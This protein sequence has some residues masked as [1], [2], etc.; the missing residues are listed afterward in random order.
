MAT[1]GPPDWNRFPDGAADYDIVLSPVAIAT[2]NFHVVAARGRKFQVCV[3]LAA[4]V[5]L[6]NTWREHGS[7]DYSV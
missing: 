5:R 7:E 2:A 4:G 3:F 1:F 6:I